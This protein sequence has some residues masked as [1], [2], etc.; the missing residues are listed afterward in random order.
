[1]WSGLEMTR[2]PLAKR[3]LDNRVAKL[4]KRA[5]SHAPHLSTP[6]TPAGRWGLVGLVDHSGDPRRLG[7]RLGQAGDRLVGVEPAGIGDD[8]DPGAREQVSLLA[9]FGLGSAKATR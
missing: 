4:V 8:P 6:L 2:S 3:V 5:R 9:A 7:V 1:M